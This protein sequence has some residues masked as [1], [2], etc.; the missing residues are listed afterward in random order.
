[1]FEWRKRDWPPQGAPMSED[2]PDYHEFKCCHC[3][4][5][6]GAYDYNIAWPSRL[7]QRALSSTIAQ[8]YLRNGHMWACDLCSREALIVS[9][10]RRTFPVP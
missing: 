2:D 10:C 5:W 6:R 8:E 4:Q 1:M 9:G 7:T 3:G